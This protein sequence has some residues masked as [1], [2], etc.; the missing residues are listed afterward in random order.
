MYPHLNPLKTKLAADEC[1]LGL[2]IQSANP[3]N[4]E[5][6]AAAGFDYVIIDLEHGSFGLSEATAMIRAAEAANICP[7]VRVPNQ[8]GSMI[9]RVAE[10][11]A[12]GVYVPDV[13]TAEQ[14]RAAVSALRF[15][16]GE[17]AGRRGACPTIRAARPGSTDW[18]RFVT[19]SNANLL[20]CLLI[21][22][23]EGMDNLDSILAVPGI[24]IVILGRFDLWHEMGLIGDRYHPEIEALFDQFSSKAREAGVPY[25]T[26]LSSLEG[27]KARREWRAAMD[28]GERIFNIA[29][30]RQLIFR[31]FSGALQPFG[32][33]A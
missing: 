4:V 32:R 12:L 16:D 13:R 7:I 27:D 6:A 15:K 29:S 18:R 23:Q 26:R 21:E 25:V 28:K 17:N 22:S 1:I 5:I 10:A 2:F 30:D 19:W 9:R 20:A 8:E 33:S 11:G 3:D 24:D 31:A 14:A